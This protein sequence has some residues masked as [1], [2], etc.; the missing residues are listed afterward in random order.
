MDLGTWE[1]DWMVREDE[2]VGNVVCEHLK[3]D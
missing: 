3:G 1:E 2:G